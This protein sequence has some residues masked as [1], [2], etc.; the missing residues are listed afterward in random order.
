MGTASLN[1]YIDLL[2]VRFDSVTKN[3]DYFF[4]INGEG[5]MFTAKIFIIQDIKGTEYSEEFDAFLMSIMPLQPK[6]L[7]I[8][9]ALTWDYIE[10]RSVKF[11]TRLIDV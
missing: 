2:S 3:V 9:G 7:K 10:G 6:I 4:D 5:K 8:L 11:P 1:H